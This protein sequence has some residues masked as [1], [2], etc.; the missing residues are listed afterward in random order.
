MCTFIFVSVERS[1]KYRLRSLERLSRLLTLNT[2]VL[3]FPN[4]KLPT[5][6]CPVLTEMTSQLESNLCTV[7]HLDEE[8]QITEQSLYKVRSFVQDSVL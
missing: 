8:L 1:N 6:E 3:V 7:S 4:A 2:L 5:G